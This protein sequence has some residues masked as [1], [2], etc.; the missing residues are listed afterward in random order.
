MRWMTRCC[1]IQIEEEEREGQ[2]LQAIFMNLWTTQANGKAIWLLT[3]K[4]QGRDLTQDSMTYVP[5]AKWLKDSNTH[6]RTT[7][8]SWWFQPE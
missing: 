6:N 5:I 3:V 7:V 4:T 8:G 2:I 1:K